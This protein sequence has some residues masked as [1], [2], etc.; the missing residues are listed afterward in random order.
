[1]PALVPAPAKRMRRLE[2]VF[3][4]ITV[5][6][7][8]WLTRVDG[9]SMNPTLHDGQLVPTYRLRRSDGVRRGDLVVIDS[10]ELGRRIV[11][12]VIGLPNEHIEMVDGRVIVAGRLLDEPYATPSGFNGSFSVPSSAFFLLGD[13]RDA[14]NDSRVWEQPYVPRQQLKGRIPP[15][16]PPANPTGH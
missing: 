10:S 9:R 14:S 15:Y 13:N 6:W 11:K 7:P 4:S 8:L 16:W 2:R 3:H 1:M 12:R 5:H